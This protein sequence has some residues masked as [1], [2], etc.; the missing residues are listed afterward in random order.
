M[1]SFQAEVILLSSANMLSDPRDQFI[2]GCIIKIV[3]RQALF[4][5]AEE[6]GDKFAMLF[7]IYNFGCLVDAKQVASD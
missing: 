2:L 3:R 6:A 1:S 5:Q 4:L 7:A